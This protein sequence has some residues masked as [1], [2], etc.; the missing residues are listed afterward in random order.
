MSL[1]PGIGAHLM[2]DVASTLL[3]YDLVDVDVPSG[4]RHGSTIWPLG[5]YLRR[6]LRQRVGLQP[7]TPH[8]AKIQAGWEMFPVLLAA[9]SHP[10]KNVAAITKE[11]YEGETARLE[12]RYQRKKGIL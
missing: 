4:L 1:R 6:R 7:E 5:R 11:I 9:W 10:T 12:G 2:D 3:Q 8:A